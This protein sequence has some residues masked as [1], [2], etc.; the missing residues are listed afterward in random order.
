MRNS[1]HTIRD[2]LKKAQAVLCQYLEP[3]G[4]DGN[5]TEPEAKL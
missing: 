2:T 5:Q 3:G 4:P 1:D